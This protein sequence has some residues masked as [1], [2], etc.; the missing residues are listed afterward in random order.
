MT[1]KLN[2]RKSLG[3]DFFSWAAGTTIKI[4]TWRPLWIVARTQIDPLISKSRFFCHPDMSKNIVQA[5]AVLPADSD[6]TSRILSRT[7]ARVALVKTSPIVGEENT[8][9]VVLSLFVS[10]KLLN[11]NRKSNDL[12]SQVLTRMKISC[13]KVLKES[14]TVPDASPARKVHKGERTAPPQLDIIFTSSASGEISEGTLAEVLSQATDLK[15][16]GEKYRLVQDPPVV[17]SLEIETQLW[18]GFPV[19][20]TWSCSGAPEEEFTFEWRI[21]SASDNALMNTIKAGAVFVP[22]EAH[23]G[24]FL[25]VHCYHPSFPEFFMSAAHVDKIGQFP[26]QKNSRLSSPLRPTDVETLRVSTFNILAQPYMRTPLAQD[27]YYTHLYKCWYV[28]EWS[29]R[30]PLILREMLDTDSDIYCLQ[31]VA[32][33]AH[34]LQL[35]RAIEATH[36]WHFFGKA[37]LANNG[38]PIGVSISLRRDKFTVIDAQKFSLGHDEQSLLQSELTEEEKA[39]ILVKFGDQFFTTVL[40]GI[41]T[42][43]GV[44]HAV[45]TPSNRHI[46]VVNTHLFFHPFGGHIRVL[47]GLCL[48]RRLDRLRRDIAAEGG[49][50]PAVVVCGDFNSRPDS[51]SFQIMRT[52]AIDQT[53]VDWQYGRSFRFDKY[54][55]EE[56]VATGTT[57][58][59]EDEAAT[60][61]VA[62]EAELPPSEGLTVQ[63]ALE[64]DIV[65]SRIPELSHATSSFRST[66][67]YIFFS[68]DSF[69]RVEGEGTG[70]SLPE[71]TNAEVDRMG[72][73]PFDHYGS[74]HVLVAGDL[75]FRTRA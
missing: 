72:G 15:V 42:V 55:V 64:L 23:V 35:K 21:V 46:L 31:E 10:G 16:E 49:E 14:I 12:V 43:A 61:A 22:S 70:S 24:C 38:N 40:K 13:A 3:R 19:V 17:T 32:G 65:P 45:H 28:T 9:Q 44:V 63:H 33:G 66:L 39:D 59:D 27:N 2:G 68:T 53:H 36:D 47:Q 73:L 11:F 34:E 54:V 18:G 5:A 74:D 58:S 29:R 51:G 26:N 71:L 60:L 4:L 25:E 50:L 30:L 1:Q 69:E 57:P 48:M 62:S 67:D 7:D 20:A 8:K 6:A 56:A 52:G 75:R 41:H 37:S